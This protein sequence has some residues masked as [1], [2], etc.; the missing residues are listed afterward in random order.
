MHRSGGSDLLPRTTMPRNI[1]INTGFQLIINNTAHH[2][3]ALVRYSVVKLILLMLP[4]QL[5]RPM[6]EIPRPYLSII[7]LENA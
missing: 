1:S 7:T 5:R 2:H 3:G 6:L 4:S